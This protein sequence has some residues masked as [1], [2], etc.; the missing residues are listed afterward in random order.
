MNKDVI[1]Q[2][3][4]IVSLVVAVA[5]NGLA[6]ALPINGITTAEISDSFAVFFVPAG[7]VFSIWG[8]IYLG[9]F[10]YAIYQA[11]PA[12]RENPRLRRTGWIFVI[13]S[14]A[15]TAWIFCWHYGYYALS[16]AVM[17]VL[18]GTLI[19]IYWRLETGRTAV[20]RAEQWAVRVP[21]SI[22]LGWIT[23]A[24]I[25]NI[26][27]LLDYVNW[28]GW[29]IAPEVWTVIMLAV[30]V[31][32]AGLMAL[33]HQDIAYLLVLVWAFAGIGVKQAETPLVAN[34]A[35]VAAAVV[36]VMVMVTAAQSRRKPRKLAYA[37]V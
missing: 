9:L 1:R 5:V 3:S 6:N 10:V 27:I 13:S 8:L 19:A 12:Q 30:A 23:V 35:W 31:V 2:I 28:N 4:V 7:Y 22:Y 17:A 24:T 21:F 36:A 20:S 33:R 32:V 34:A 26:T 25:A 16:V 14:I 29:G 11:L 15:N 37:A 18:L